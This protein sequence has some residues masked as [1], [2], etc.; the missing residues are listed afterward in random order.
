MKIDQI[1]VLHGNSRK[2]WIGH[3]LISNFLFQHDIINHHTDATGLIITSTGSDPFF[4]Y[5]GNLVKDIEFLPDYNKVWAEVAGLLLLNI[6]VW[7][8]LVLSDKIYRKIQTLP[9]P[10][11]NIKILKPQ[12]VFV[13]FAIVFGIL[14][15]LITPPFQGP[16]EPA[17]FFRVYQLASGT[18]FPVTNSNRVGGYIPISLVKT[19]EIFKGI[20]FHPE[21]KIEYKMI[22]ESFNIRLQPNK[23][24][25]IPFPN[26]ALYMPV[27]YIPQCLAIIAGKAFELPPLIL[28]Y[29]GRLFNL[30]CWI[31]LVAFA[32]R[33]T[34]INKWLFLIL[35]LIP[36]SLF[37]GSSLSADGLTNGL[38]FLYI[39]LV[40]K[41]AF[42]ENQYI[43]KFEM[44]F[45][46]IL[47]MLLSLSKYAY[48]LLGFLYF[49]I[50][51]RKSESNAKSLLYVSLLFLFVGLT[52]AFGFYYV[53]YIY[54]SVDPGVNFYGTA[55]GV[56]QNVNPD[57]QVRFI[58]THAFL[59]L[60]I[61]FFSF[62]TYRGLILGS[63]I[64][65][66]GW[67][68]TPLPG[69]FIISA[70]IVLFFVACSGNALRIRMSLKSRMILFICFCAICFCLSTLMYLSWSPAGAEINSGIQGRYLIP[71]APVFFALFFN[72]RWIVPEKAIQ[73]I[74]VLFMAIS[75]LVLTAELISRYYVG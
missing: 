67:L 8:L 4:E 58:L 49:L 73:V 16:D 69:L 65:R 56:P 18:F 22:T 39:A 20:Q 9:N 32:I 55:P 30:G 48:A 57:I 42:D 5:K 10:L 3:A 66:L 23:L 59:F 74:S 45:L 38:A 14:T 44:F 72:S 26:T 51:C 64:G 24:M 35:A 62:W 34:P 7:C 36:M 21:K 40:F 61:V 31:I 68:D 6:L 71:A 41:M 70:Y 54:G 52:L 25:F 63:F 60:K 2:C 75:S 12:E 37:Q 13:S 27:P 15:V 1:C 19:H 33:I 17:H 47:L 29:M 28:L 11:I 50:P 43:N 46:I 53:K